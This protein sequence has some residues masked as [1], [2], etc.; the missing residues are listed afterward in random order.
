MQSVLACGRL[1]A[2]ALLGGGLRQSERREY[3]LITV[4]CGFGKDLRKGSGTGAKGS[5]YGDDA[6][7]VATHRLA[8]VLGV[9]DGVGG[10]WDYGVDPSQ[11]STTLMQTCSSTACLVILDRQKRCLY[12][13]N[14]GD[15]GFLIVRDGRI[16]H[17]SDEQ[18]HYFNTP[19]QLAI[20]PPEA[21]DSILND[22]PET[23]EGSTF[24]VEVGDIILTA[25]DGL[26]DNMPDYMILQ[27][28]RQL[29]DSSYQSMKET[30]K[31]IAEQAQQLAYDP[32]YMSPFA[33]HACENGLNVQGGK[34]DDITV[35]LS[36]VT[37]SKE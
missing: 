24:N 30:V 29:K 5:G 15:S 17:R 2:R 9:A 3:R 33:Q 16:I 36:V 32:N 20:A 13:A 4:S 35:L 7:F 25:T 12:T 1:V 10:W 8:D 14:L 21:Q 28:L 31:S 26:F 6:C 22:S 34:P 19:F 37:E 11:F 18:Q 27:Q 23:A